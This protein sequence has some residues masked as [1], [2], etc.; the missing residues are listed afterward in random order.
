MINK[1]ELTK[2]INDVTKQYGHTPTVAQ[3]ITGHTAAKSVE[4][5]LQS[6]ETNFGIDRNMNI[7][8][9]DG[10]D[11]I[12]LLFAMT[13]HEMGIENYNKYWKGNEAMLMYYLKKGYDLSKKK[14]NMS[15]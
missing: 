5:Y 3:I 13:K 1:S 10:D 9:L 8:L 12:P 14:Y 6:L 4:G 11:V 2:G 15:K 7:N